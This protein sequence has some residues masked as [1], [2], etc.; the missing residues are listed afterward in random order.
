M[1]QRCIYEGENFAG[2]GVFGVNTPHLMEK[3]SISIAFLGKNFYNSLHT[4][5]YPKGVR[6]FRT[7]FSRKLLPIFF[8]AFFNS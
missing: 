4:P 5:S 6:S 3:I 8:R 2:E 1:S 7:L